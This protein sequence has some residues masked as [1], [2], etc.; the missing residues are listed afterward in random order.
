MENP[1]LLPSI[2]IK[3]FYLSKICYLKK[4][5]VILIHPRHTQH[6]MTNDL[7][8]AKN[9]FD[10]ALNFIN[11]SDFESAEKEL[12]AANILCPNRISILVNLYFTLVNLHKWD[13]NI[14]ICSEILNVDSTNLDGL[15]NLAITH[16]Q[17]GQATL[18]KEYISRALEINPRSHSAWSNFGNIALDNKDY[19]KAKEYFETSIALNPQ[20]EE[21]YIGLGNLLNEQSEYKKAIDYFDFALSINPLNPLASWNKSLSLLRLG[22]FTH[23]WRLYESRWQIFGMKQNK[24]NLSTKLWLGDFPIRGQV[25]HIY[26]EQGYGDIIQMARFLPIIGTKFSAQVIFETSN[27]LF[28]L[29]KSLSPSITIIRTNEV[30]ISK[31]GLSPT[32]HCPI[33]SLPLAFKTKINSIPQDTPYLFANASKTLKWSVLFNKLP[34][35]SKD[36]PPFRVGICT[37]GSGHYAGKPNSKRDV[38][39]CL[40]NQ[41]LTACHQFS[42]EWHALNLIKDS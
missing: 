14:R 26:S 13:A 11:L 6:N 36:R 42:I 15:I 27:P 24:K 25:I 20:S 31:D 29:C 10:L 19:I 38:P 1:F 17:L 40:V 23:G 30:P 18:A 39:G 41:I 12:V 8:R 35:P 34:W 7:D 9:Y 28:E 37:Q 32:F 33:M 4:I 2:L 16:H 21:S 5:S 3:L 22:D